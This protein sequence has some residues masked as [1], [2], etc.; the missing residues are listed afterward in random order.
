MKKESK[1]LHK[2][3]LY[4]LGCL[5]L[6]CFAQT[7]FAE[8]GFNPLFDG[9]SLDGWTA[10]KSKGDKDWGAFSINNEE[11]AIHVYAGK[12]QG[13]KQE[14][15]CLVTKKQFSHYI[16]RMEYKWLEKRFEPR[17]NWDRDAG[18]LFHVHGDLKKVWPN[19]FEMQ[20]GET[21]GHVTAKSEDY[22][23]GR[24]PKHRFHSGDFFTVSTKAH[25]RSQTK[26]KGNLWHPKGESITIYG[27]SI[28]PFGKEKAK[29]KW[30][31][32]EIRVHGHK[33][34]T[35]ILN[36][37]V[38]FE[39]MNMEQKKDGKFVPIKKGHIGLQAES[40][41]LLY[42]NIGIKELKEEK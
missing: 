9:T 17:V 14:Y 26:R 6:V 35:F 3:N 30:N 23:Q 31:E 11:R 25:L 36:G 40:A 42:R 41:E 19:C 12:K 37:E 32:V 18:L 13:S 7:T 4:L 21:P 10:A 8:E 33:K 1:R 39:T 34:A 16:L 27:H 5:L 38:V 29:G 15:D 24:K 28:T 20:I 22:W 2:L